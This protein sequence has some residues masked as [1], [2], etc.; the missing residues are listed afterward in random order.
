MKIRPVGVEFFHADTDR[1]TDERTDNHDEL[2]V[3]FRNFANAPK[4]IHGSIYEI[5]LRKCS[6]MNQET[7][8]K[9]AHEHAIKE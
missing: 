4:Y 8:A 9:R 6:E 5:Y 2:I 3:A 7:N 1:W